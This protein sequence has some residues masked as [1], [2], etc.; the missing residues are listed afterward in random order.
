MSLVK[1][2][3][4]KEFGLYISGKEGNLREQLS[5][6]NLED[7]KNIVLQIAENIHI[8]SLIEIKNKYIVYI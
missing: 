7:I 6:I 4:K 3:I 5:L 1:P 2:C 8:D